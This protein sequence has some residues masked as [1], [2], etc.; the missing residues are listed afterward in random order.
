[1][2]YTTKISKYKFIIGLLEFTPKNG[3]G[4]ADGTI[5]PYHKNMILLLINIM[6]TKNISS[7]KK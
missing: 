2:I 6:Y 1:M 7:Y 4:V 5:F 3:I